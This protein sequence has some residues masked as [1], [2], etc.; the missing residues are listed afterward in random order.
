MKALD[1]IKKTMQAEVKPTIAQQAK[2]TSSSENPTVVKPTL[3]PIVS[4]AP[5]VTTNPIPKPTKTAPAVPK[6]TD[7]ASWWDMLNSEPETSPEEQAKIDKRQR[8]IHN[9]ASIGDAIASVSNLAATTQ[10]AQSAYN[11]ATN[12]TDAARQRYDAAEALRQKN[13]LLKQAKWQDKMKAI[14]DRAKILQ[15]QEAQR[16]EEEYRNRQLTNEEARQAEMVRANMVKEGQ[17]DKRIG[18]DE[19]TLAANIKKIEADAYASRQRGNSYTA[20]DK[21]KMQ[22]FVVGNTA[23]KIPE[24]IFANNTVGRAN[25]YNIFNEVVPAEYQKK[26]KESNFL[27]DANGIPIKDQTTGERVYKTPS[28]ED[29]E[30]Y[31]A[32]YGD[33]TK[34]QTALQRISGQQ[35]TVAPA[36][37]EGDN[38][39]RP[40]KTTRTGGLKL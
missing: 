1:V 34:L 12:L 39:E 9:I 15:E 5:T 29:L 7:D 2:Q 10:G 38:A 11:P 13:L 26:L 20:E 4:A 18:Q 17:E 25:L 35:T 19:K 37:K 40:Y 28:T 23:V 31:I 33:P 3:N 16:A 14:S 24:N 21:I 32:T 27:V 30:Y 36:T 22:D 8:A 6:A